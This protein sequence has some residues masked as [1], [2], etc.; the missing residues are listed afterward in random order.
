[1]VEFLGVVVGAKYDRKAAI[2]GFVLEV[3]RDMKNHRGLGWFD[4]FNLGDENVVGIG[5]KRFQRD[6]SSDD[7]QGGRTSEQKRETSEPLG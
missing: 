2:A 4:C 5:Q 7:C 3:F 6:R 1:M